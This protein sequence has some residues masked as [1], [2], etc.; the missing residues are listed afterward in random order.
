M[1]KMRGKKYT[2]FLMGRGNVPG[3][4]MNSHRTGFPYI[5]QKISGKKLSLG[6]SWS[7]AAITYQSEPDLNENES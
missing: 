3:A 2:C 1:P 7:R 6:F 5:L 4:N